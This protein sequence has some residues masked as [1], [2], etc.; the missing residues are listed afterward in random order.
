M[1]TFSLAF[2][3][4]FLFVWDFGIKYE[5]RRSSSRLQNSSKGI[6]DFGLSFEVVLGEVSPTTSVKPQDEQNLSP[7]ENLYSQFEQNN[8]G[9]SAMMVLSRRSPLSYIIPWRSGSYT[10]LSQPSVRKNMA[11]FDV[12]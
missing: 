10:F 9:L 11:D 12:N 2:V 1:V 7:D 5:E 8:F 3:G 4:V 6:V